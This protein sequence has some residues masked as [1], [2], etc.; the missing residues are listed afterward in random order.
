MQG[1]W[2]FLILYDSDQISLYQIVPNNKYYTL[3][4]PNMELGY[5]EKDPIWKWL[6]KEWSY[7]IPSNSVA[8]TN[9]SAL[10][11]SRI[12][13]ITRW[14]VNEWEMFAGYGP[15]IAEEEVRIVPISILLGI[16]SSVGESINL[17]VGKGIW[18]EQEDI[19]WEAWK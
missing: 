15:D 16:D 10:R 11:G 2:E 3:E 1:L 12:T 6:T 13:E 7:P 9:L 5:S 4:V 18:R 14:E 19:N 17:E 8:I